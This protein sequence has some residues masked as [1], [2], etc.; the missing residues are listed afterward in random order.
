MI[1]RRLPVGDLDLSTG[2]FQRL[3]GVDYAK[4]KIR[5][6]LLFIKGEWILDT[7]LGQPWFEEI[8]V[9]NPDLRLIQRRVR[10][11]LLGVPGITN[12]RQVEIQFDRPTRNLSLAY[13]ADF[14]GA[15]EAITD[16]LQSPIV[17]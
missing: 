6:R 14:V 3:S 9:K 7:R 11:V 10:D 8:L 5:Q 17:A 13:V 2:T 15:S 4:Q 12:V 16:V 1:G